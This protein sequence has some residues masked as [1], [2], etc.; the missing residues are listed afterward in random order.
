VPRPYWDHFIAS[1]RRHIW[2]GLHR[3]LP[4]LRATTGADAGWIGAAAVAARKVSNFRKQT[5]SN[6]Q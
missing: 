1:T 3:D 6:T 2:S 4:V 5:A